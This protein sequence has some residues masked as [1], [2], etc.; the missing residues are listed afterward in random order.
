MLIHFEKIYLIFISICFKLYL[1]IFWGLLLLF[2]ITWF[3]WVKPI[4]VFKQIEQVDDEEHICWKIFNLYFEINAI[5]IKKIQFFL[6]RTFLP[7]KYICVII[8]G[9]KHIWSPWKLSNFKT[10]TPLVHLRSKFFY[11]FDLGCPISNE[12]PLQMI[13]NQLQDNII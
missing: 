11:P 8:L 7:F 3:L 6:P 9:M 10:T 2:E 4:C 13:T 1:I 12:P 5:I